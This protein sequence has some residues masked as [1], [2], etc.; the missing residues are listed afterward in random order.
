M[1]DI[2]CGRQPLKRLPFFYSLSSHGA[3]LHQDIIVQ[4]T[5]IPRTL[6]LWLPLVICSPIKSNGIDVLEF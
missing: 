5:P 1:L 6:K 3:S 4:S 2:L